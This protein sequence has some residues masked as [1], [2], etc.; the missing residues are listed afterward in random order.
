MDVLFFKKQQ[1][2]FLLW[3][4]NKMMIL[5]SGLTTKTLQYVLYITGLY[6]S[7]CSGF[8]RSLMEAVIKWWIG[9]CP[10]L[11][12]TTARKKESAA[13]LLRSLSSAVTTANSNINDAIAIIII[14]KAIGSTRGDFV[15]MMLLMWPSSSVYQRQAKY[16]CLPCICLDFVGGLWMMLMHI[17]PDSM[18]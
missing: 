5:R 3:K 11:T 13:C 15:I 18:A 7:Y 10:F 17:G 12:S 1:K 16:W 6:F 2:S 8:H 9:L 14:C 4:T